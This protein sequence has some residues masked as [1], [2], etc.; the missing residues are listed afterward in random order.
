L[1]LPLSWLRDFVDLPADW[2]A[3]E[4]ARRLTAA[5]LEVEGIAA[6]A[7]AFSDVV[8]G[9][10]VRAERHPQADKLQ[11]CQVVTGGTGDTGGS[12]AAP[13]QIVC[14]APNAR[15]GLVSALARVGARLPDDV[16]IAAATLRGVTS[17]GMLCSARELGLSD[18]ADGIVELADD[19]PLGADLRGYLDL[20]DSI[21]EVN[22]TPNRGDAMSVLGV[23]RDVA[24]LTGSALLTPARL[25]T[26]A[27]G[28]AVATGDDAF[29]V[30]LQPLAG[31]PR[32]LAQVL[33][34]LDN[35]RATPLWLR[36]RLRRAGLRSISPVVDVTNY[37]ML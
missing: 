27:A 5:G 2:D 9:R 34:G 1:K 23:A 24:V 22:V 28:S 3:S 32:L 29:P 36:E 19:A 6:A 25:R 21:L 8:V 17:Q 15:P 31:A 30:S 7:A 18:A 4:L 12:A 20:D 26:G 16:T 33:F 10:I 13:L 11:V 14:G 37:V 35:R